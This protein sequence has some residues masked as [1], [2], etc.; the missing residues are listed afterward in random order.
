MTRYACKSYYDDDAQDKRWAVERQDGN[1]KRVLQR[2]FI[3]EEGAQVFLDRYTA[4]KKNKHISQNLRDQK[5]RAIARDQDPRR[6]RTAWGPKNQEKEHHHLHHHPPTATAST[7]STPYYSP[8]DRALLMVKRC[9]STSVQLS[10]DCVRAVPSTLGCRS[11]G[12]WT[13]HICFVPGHWYANPIALDICMS[14]LCCG[15]CLINNAH[16]IVTEERVALIRANPGESK[17]QLCWGL[18]NPGLCF[19]CCCCCNR[20]RIVKHYQLDNHETCAESWCFSCCCCF[21]AHCQE[22]NEVAV[23]NQYG[24][25]QQP[26]GCCCCPICLRAGSAQGKRYS[27]RN[28]MGSRVGKRSMGNQMMGTNSTVTTA[29]QVLRVDRRHGEDDS[30]DGVHHHVYR[31][32][33]V[34]TADRSVK[35]VPKLDL[36]RDEKQVR[37][38]PL[39]IGWSLDLKPRGVGSVSVREE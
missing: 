11:K 23:R 6:A 8:T 30:N 9:G 13:Q 7:T 5:R 12:S 20:R 4:I 19:L 25:L 10:K 1:V 37:K 31:G 36:G 26:C 39:K 16:K 21:C 27:N 33:I 3:T 15:P 18:L 34:G 24:H 17:Q 2:C 28:V 38:N 35:F 14:C 22:M 29:P 32:N